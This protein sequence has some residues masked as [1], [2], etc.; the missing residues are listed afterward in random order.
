MRIV[1]RRINCH[2]NYTTRE[3]HHGKNV[4]LT[5]K[6]AVRARKGDMG[7]IPGSMGASTYIV[8]GLGNE[9]SYQSCS[10]GAGRR[11]SRGRAKRELSLTDFEAQMKGRVWNSDA[12]D[13]L[14]DEAPGSYKSIEQVMEDQRD[15]VVIRYRL[16]Q[17]LNYKGV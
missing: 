10:H 11:L 6:G 14:L 15:L 9:A 3:N 1:R 2:H 7:I 5:R 4:W 13:R 12:S 8:E 17:I 16:H